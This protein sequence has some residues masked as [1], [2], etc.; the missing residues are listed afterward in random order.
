MP[1][2]PGLDR[3]RTGRLANL[4]VAFEPLEGWRHYEV[5]ARRTRADFAHFVRDLLEGRYKYATKVVLVMDN[6][7]THNVASLYAA[8]PPA[9]ARRLP[10]RLGIHHTPKHGSW[11]SVAEIDLAALDRRLPDRLDDAAELACH[12]AAIEKDRNEAGKGCD[13]RFTTAGVREP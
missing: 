3:S 10:E 13:W 2:T 4:F 1:T 9:E 6:L 11:L 7:N 5:T 12:A 8:F